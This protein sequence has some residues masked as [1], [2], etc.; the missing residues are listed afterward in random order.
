LLGF[1]PL[2]GGPSTWDSHLFGPI[3]GRGPIS[4]DFYPVR[5]VQLGGTEHVKEEGFR[6]D[7]KK[8]VYICPKG[9]KLT[10]KS[11]HRKVAYYRL[12]TAVCEAC[13][14]F[15]QCVPKDRYAYRR[16]KRITRDINQ[17]LF[18]EVL[19]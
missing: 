3:S 4:W 16:G 11:D 12:P 17:A 15:D 6:Y 19:E 14:L 1:G 13:P 7:E 8:D 2:G 10:R 9:K 18:E 5:G